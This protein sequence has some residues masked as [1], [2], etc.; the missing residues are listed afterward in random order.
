MDS[1]QYD[2]ASRL[3][4]LRDL[5]AQLGLDSLHREP[6]SVPPPAPKAEKVQERAVF[7]EGFAP[8]GA[9]PRVPV[10]NIVTTPPEILPPSPAPEKTERREE[11]A[12][13]A[14]GPSKSERPDGV[15]DVVTLPSKRGQ[16]RKNR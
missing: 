1:G 9:T 6:E 14:A 11:S 16:Y 15:D 3:G 4:G 10:P 7:S 13:S 5:L 12:R 2:P 8:Y